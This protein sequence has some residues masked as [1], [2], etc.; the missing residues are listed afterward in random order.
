MNIF[1]SYTTRDRYLNS[2]R[3]RDINNVVCKYGS[4]FI[5]AL[6]NNSEN[7]QARVE[8]EL[9]KA[10]II[11]FIGT[12]GC[13]QSEWVEWERRNAVKYGK[14]CV[15]VPFDEEKP[16][17]TNLR[18][19]ELALIKQSAT[20]CKWTGILLRN[21]SASNSQGSRIEEVQQCIRLI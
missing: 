15:E 2:D 14:Q 5:D 10:S 17:F 16:W 18:R 3:L 7:R 9:T 4:V 13:S 8:E 1:I 12:S 6:H 19:V 21:I 20:S 11:L